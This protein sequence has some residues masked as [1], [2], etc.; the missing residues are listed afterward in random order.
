LAD[1]TPTKPFSISTHAPTP[2]NR[3]DVEE[4]IV[5][6][7]TRYGRPRAEVEAEIQG[8]YI[9]ESVSSLGDGIL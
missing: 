7:A 6:S 5:A 4:R 9:K 8:R 2:I 1:G 3:A